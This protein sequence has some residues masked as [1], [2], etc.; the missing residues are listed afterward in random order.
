MQKIVDFQG[1][2]QYY[3]VKCEKFHKKYYKRNGAKH[4]AKPFADHKDYAYKLE[5]YES[6]RI[7]FKRQWRNYAKWQKTNQ[8]PIGLPKKRKK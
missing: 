1:I 8:K 7:K 6:F 4:K 2:N 5:N 3:C